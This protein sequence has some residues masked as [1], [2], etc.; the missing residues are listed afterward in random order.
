MVRRLADS[1]ERGGWLFITTPNPESLAARF[2][3]SS[4]SGA[5][6]PSH[7]VLMRA[8]TLTR[9]LR[10]AGFGSVERLNQRI[11]FTT[12]PLKLAC[13]NL[14]QALRLDGQLRMLAR[15]Q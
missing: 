10:E 7:L 8:A 11:R 15:R 6:N 5:S 1:L 13:R 9:L 2:K 3:G 4:W 12:G 14:L